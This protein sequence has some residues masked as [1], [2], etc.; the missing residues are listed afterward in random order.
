MSTETELKL[1]TLLNVSAIKRPR[2]MDVP[3]GQRGSSS[4]S[5]SRAASPAVPVV[6]PKK[7]KSVVFGGELGPSGSTF[8]KKAKSVENGNGVKGKGKGK[9]INLNGNGNGNGHAEDG[10]E[11][12]HESAGHGEI[13][14]DVGSDDET[15]TLTG[16]LEPQA[17]SLYSV[18]DDADDHFNAHFAT[19]PDILTDGSI[20]SVAENKWITEKTILKGYGKAVQLRPTGSTSQT[21]DVKTRVSRAIYKSLCS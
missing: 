2:D 15:S 3:G 19:T 16:K 17:V 8:G 20:A 9:E 11:N 21:A 6:Q 5:G 12:G 10:D 7:R 13:E 18:A 14:E 1:L 4:Q